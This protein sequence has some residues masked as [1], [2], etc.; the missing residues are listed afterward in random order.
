MSRVR[1]VQ[2]RSRRIPARLLVVTAL[3]GASAIL[4]PAPTVAAGNAVPRCAELAG[5]QV[6]ASVITLPTRGG[7]VVSAT[8]ANQVVSG[9]T[10][11]YCNVQAAL[12]PIDPS[13]P[14]IRLRIGM[15]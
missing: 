6:P 4:G 10:I 11:E 5:T 15:P 9:K 1:R 13:A 2:E 8:V 3:V 12:S 14:D 7:R